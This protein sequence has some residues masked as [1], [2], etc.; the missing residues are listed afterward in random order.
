VSAIENVSTPDIAR[1]LARRLRSGDVEP[2]TVQVCA[3]A[4]ESLAVL[5]ERS[6]G[7]LAKALDSTYELEAMLRSLILTVTPQRTE[8]PERK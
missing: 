6:Q 3:F 4:L 2:A 7:V 5:Y 8:T 1:E